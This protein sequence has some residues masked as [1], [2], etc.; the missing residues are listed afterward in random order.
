MS[1]D[2]IKEVLKDYDLLDEAISKDEYIKNLAPNYSSYMDEAVKIIEYSIDHNEEI[3]KGNSYNI[4]FTYPMSN[5]GFN[6]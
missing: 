3:Q 1:D 2:L 4:P 5:L 6:V